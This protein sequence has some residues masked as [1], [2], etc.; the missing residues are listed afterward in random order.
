M[1][2]TNWKEVADSPPYNNESLEA[3]P[4]VATAS[5]TRSL[6]STKYN[7]VLRCC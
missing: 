7:D 2:S 3:K 6:G 1:K 5:L 4:R